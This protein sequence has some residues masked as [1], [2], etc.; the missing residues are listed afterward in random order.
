VLD[1]GY[2]VLGAYGHW[3]IREQV[4]GGTTRDLLKISELPL[5]LAH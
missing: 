5:V 2:V 1:V 4:L 3:R